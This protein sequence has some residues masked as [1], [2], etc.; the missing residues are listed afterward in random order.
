MGGAK[1]SLED[2]TSGHV[3]EEVRAVIP[4]NSGKQ[5]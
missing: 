5:V 3:C 2:G 1:L 4:P